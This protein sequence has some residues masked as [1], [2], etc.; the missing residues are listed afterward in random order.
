MAKAIISIEQWDE[1]A[2]I[3]DQALS[4]QEIANKLLEL[5]PDDL[6]DVMKTVT[7]GIM[8]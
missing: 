5:D 3:E 1:E 2:V 7:E 4:P 6:Q 8:L